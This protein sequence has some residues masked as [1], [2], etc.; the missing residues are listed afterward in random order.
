MLL[1]LLGDCREIYHH[2]QWGK[3]RVRM[4]GGG[5]NYIPQARTL[6]PFSRCFALLFSALG[7][8][9]GAWAPPRPPRATTWAPY[10]GRGPIWPILVTLRSALLT[11]SRP[12][13]LPDEAQKGSRGV[14]V[15]VA[16][17]ENTDA[18]VAQLPHRRPQSGNSRE[19]S[20]VE[21]SNRR[22]AL[23]IRGDRQ[24]PCS[25]LSTSSAPPI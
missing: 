25:G 14:V 15:L 16:E 5:G 22:I 2:Y 6:R 7:R 10:S 3:K 8:P 1:L 11:H 18:A 19:S 17:R 12:I 23:F 4:H 9:T 13:S 21:R 20:A 24:S